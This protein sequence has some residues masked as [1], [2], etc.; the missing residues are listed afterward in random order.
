MHR[1]LGLIVALFATL[2]AAA[3]AAQPASDEQQLRDIQQG[4][5]RAWLQKD[6]AYIETVFAPEWSVTQADGSLLTRVP[7]D[8]LEAD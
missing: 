7:C 5:A 6:R 4:L 2:L 8:L 1:T 3:A